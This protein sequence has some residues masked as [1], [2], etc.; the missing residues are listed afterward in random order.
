MNKK[1]SKKNI[2][3]TISILVA[4]LVIIFTIKAIYIVDNPKWFDIDFDKKGSIIS[5]YAA[6]VGSL[7]TFLSIL[8]VIYTIIQQKDLHEKNL[9]HKEKEELEKLYDNILFCQNYLDKLIDIVDKTGGYLKE[10]YEKEKEHPLKS[11]LLYFTIYMELNPFLELNSVEIF[12]SFQVF[13]EKETNVKHYNTL[14]S[15]FHFY[16]IA[17]K[18]LK[19]KYDNYIIDKV[20][21]KRKLVR[22][23]N[24][25]I[26]EIVYL[27]EEFEKRNLESDPWYVLFEEFIEKYYQSINNEEEIDLKFLKDENLKDFIKKTIELKKITKVYTAKSTNVIILKF[28]TIRKEIYSLEF[29]SLNYAKQ[30]E[31]NYKNYYSKDSEFLKELYQLR[32]DLKKTIPIDEILK[33]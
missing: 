10:F 17:I 15:K 25:N 24:S 19:G 3:I 2:I 31:G 28:S 16:S 18:E 1:L 29:D 26:D 12:K 33:K 32:D 21:I 9:K 22:D 27:K 14:Y 7:L 20:N 11:N 23:I 13:Y 4:F 6:L 5:S 8:F 30:L